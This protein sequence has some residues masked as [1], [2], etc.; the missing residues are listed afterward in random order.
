MILQDAISK[1]RSFNLSKESEQ[2]IVSDPKS[3]NNTLKGRLRFIK[4][5]NKK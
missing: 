2:R 5:M 4:S 3:E 1:Y